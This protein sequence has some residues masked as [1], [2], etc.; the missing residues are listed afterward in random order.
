[1]K[2]LLSWDELEPF[3]VAVKNGDVKGLVLA[4][5]NNEAATKKLGL[6]AI[7]CMMAHPSDAN[8][9]QLEEVSQS[10]Q[11]I[12][13]CRLMRSFSHQQWL[14]DKKQHVWRCYKSAQRVAADVLSA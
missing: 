5:R 7:A 6:Q 1:M 10:W 8:R 9:R 14:N 13:L 2:T 4:A 12:C 11:G 3:V